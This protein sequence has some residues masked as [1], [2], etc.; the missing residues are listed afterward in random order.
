MSALIAVH[1]ASFMTSGIGKS[2]KPCARFTALCMDAMRVISRM[3]DSVNVAV[4]RAAS[5]VLSSDF[6]ECA[7]DQLRGTRACSRFIDCLAHRS[8]GVA[9]GVTE[10]DERANRILG[11][12][13][14]G[15]GTPRTG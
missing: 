12:G 8:L 1:A 6:A 7:T 15:P 5:T 9:R 14:V 2:G 4:R 13:A 10:R 11:A 3:T